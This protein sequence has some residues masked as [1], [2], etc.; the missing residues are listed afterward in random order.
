[1]NW[2]SYEINLCVVDTKGKKKHSKNTQVNNL[3][4]GG[5]HK[6]TNPSKQLPPSTLFL[7]SLFVVVVIVVVVVVVR[8]QKINMC[9]N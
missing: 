2:S 1:M 8:K 3:N 4:G 5:K 6:S 7:F 9:K